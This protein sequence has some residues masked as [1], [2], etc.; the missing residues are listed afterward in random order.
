M[1][2]QSSEDEARSLVDNAQIEDVRRVCGPLCDAEAR[3]T[4]TGP[5]FGERNVPMNCIHLF[6]KHLL[7]TG[8]L[9]AVAP[10]TI[11]RQWLNAFTL[12]GRVPVTKY[13]FN[14]KYLEGSAKVTQWTQELIDSQVA[15]A[16]RG[17]LAGTYGAAHRDALLVVL[18]VLSDTGAHLHPKQ[19]SLSCD[20]AKNSI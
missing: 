15:E 13:Y 7:Q 19:Y 5:F 16:K 10:K 12:N 17:A 18:P 6:G 9:G 11:P 4:E 3:P 14:Q 20:D 1:R 8:N 2:A